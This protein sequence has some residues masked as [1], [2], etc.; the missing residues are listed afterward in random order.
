MAR[1]DR[2]RHK[3]RD[4]D[5]RKRDKDDDDDDDVDDHDKSDNDSNNS[6]SGFSG[7]GGSD[8]DT[9]MQFVTSSNDDNSDN[10]DN[11][12]DENQNDKDNDNSSDNGDTGNDYDNF[13]QHVLKAD[14][15][16]PLL[17]PDPDDDKP[18]VKDDTDILNPDKEKEN[19]VKILKEDR[20]DELKFD[21]EELS[22]IKGSSFTGNEL[23]EYLY[24]RNLK[25]SD[26]DLFMKYANKGNNNNEDNNNENN[27]EEIDESSDCDISINLTEDEYFLQWDFDEETDFKSTFDDEACGAAVIMNFIADQYKMQTGLALTEDQAHMVMKTATEKFIRD[28]D[29]YI[30][31]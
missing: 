5:K 4:R 28:T 14:P 22:M 23:E 24:A 31:N 30:S 20:W 6:F 9:Y 13:F 25:Q 27:N 19:L 29:A 2:D 8:Y 15:P 1:K 12:D 11:D 7:G 3:D 21:E 26:Y 10:D 18:I 16:T 17:D